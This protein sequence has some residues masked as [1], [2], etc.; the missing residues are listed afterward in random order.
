MK[1]LLCLS[2]VLVMLLCCLAACVVQ[3]QGSTPGTTTTQPAPTTTQPTPPWTIDPGTQPPPTT[4]PTDPT[5]QPTDPTT[6]PT[7]PPTQPTEPPTQPTEPPTQPTEPPT[8]PT[9]PPTQPTEPPTQPTEPPTQPTEPPTQPTE[10]PAPPVGSAENPAQLAIG[11][12]VVTPD[13][14]FWFTWV[15]EADATLMLE[16]QSDSAW[17]Y[18]IFNVTAGEEMTLKGSSAD[19]LP[20][21]PAL[22]NVMQGDELCIVVR[23]KS[24]TVT[25]LASQ[26]DPM[27][28]ELSPLW[29]YVSHT[30]Y[31]RV[32]A[33]GTL[34][35]TERAQG[36]T[37]VI[38]NAADALVS[39]EGQTYAPENG[40]IQ[41]KM[42]ALQS[43]R[44]EL[45]NFSITNQ[46][47]EI[48]IYAVSFQI[49]LGTL[50]NPDTLVIGTNVASVEKDDPDGYIFHYTATADGVLTITM[51]SDADWCYSLYNLT[52]YASSAQ[53]YSNEDP[54]TISYSM[55]VK[56]GDVVQIS[57]S[58]F[59]PKRPNKIPAGEVTF[60]A[61]FQP[62][63]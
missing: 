62:A 34:Y 11:E 14:E 41:V 1:K 47:D 37:M 46:S 59:N 61:E 27:G 49:P 48:Q 38:T 51:P 10:P 43:G 26:L 57:V 36:T 25:L 35:F 4:R 52:S 19:E 3:T 54:Q 8:Q 58:T 20:A 32:P 17:S 24:G 31:I 39:F 22:V 28:T 56:A 60:T 21:T 53:F 30:T 2:L 29:V 55:N 15:A 7:E 63:E 18:E 23:A 50:E 40:T 16:L 13:G 12:N 45:L 33:G 6:Q 9:E 42:P 5:T 44:A